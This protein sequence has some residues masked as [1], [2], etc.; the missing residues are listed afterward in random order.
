MRITNK[1]IIDDGQTTVSCS[2]DSKSGTHPQIFLNINP[3]D[4]KIECYYCGKTFCWK[5]IANIKKPIK[6]LKYK[7]GGKNVLR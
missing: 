5:S 6:K 1:V 2:G 4:G 7:K 3:K